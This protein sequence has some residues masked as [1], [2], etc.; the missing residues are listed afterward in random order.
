M[1]NLQTGTIQEI[2]LKDDDV[3]K[4]YSIGDHYWGD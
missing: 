1:A 3:N 4:V 2:N